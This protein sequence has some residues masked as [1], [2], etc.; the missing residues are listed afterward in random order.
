MWFPPPP[1]TGTEPSD[2][3]WAKTFTSQ[4]T[5]AAQT[6]VQR[7]PAA[8]APTLAAP[9]AV[10]DPAPSAPP[11]PPPAT[12]QP[13]AARPPYACMETQASCASSCDYYGGG[14]AETPAAPQ[15]TPAY[16]PYPDP[17][18]GT[19]EGL[20]SQMSSKASYG[21]YA[22][23]AAYP[24]YPPAAPSYGTP[25]A[26]YPPPAAAYIGAVPP[27]A[28]AAHYGPAPAAYCAPAPPAYGAYGCYKPQK[29][30]KQQQHHHHGALG[31]AAAVGAT[32]G[33]V[34]GLALLFD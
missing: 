2:N 34:A 30:W 14:A 10:S 26:G 7:P 31:G 25:P 20:D 18:A 21:Y 32:L 11:L 28:P 13:P 19:E 23:P 17:A 27:P 12:S 29:P 5:S 1:Q 33:A 8:A 4:I 22:A 6:S 24:A 16:L 15:P 3:S 9:L